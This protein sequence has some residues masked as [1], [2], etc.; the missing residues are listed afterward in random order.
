[1]SWDSVRPK[2]PLRTRGWDMNSSVN[3]SPLWTEEKAIQTALELRRVTGRGGGGCRLD[4]S[5]IPEKT[6]KNWKGYRLRMKIG[7]ENKI[8][9]CWCER[10]EKTQKIFCRRWWKYGWKLDIGT[11]TCK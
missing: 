6:G 4:E 1:M 11:L 9:W 8:E 2:E 7:M 3:K 10:Q 5:Y